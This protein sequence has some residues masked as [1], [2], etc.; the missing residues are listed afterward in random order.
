MVRKIKCSG[1]GGEDHHDGEGQE[2][3][4]LSGLPIHIWFEPHLNKSPVISFGKKEGW[5][6]IGA[7]VSDSLSVDACQ[8]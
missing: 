8:V 1:D 7:N 6:G 5:R 4:D 3:T 2:T